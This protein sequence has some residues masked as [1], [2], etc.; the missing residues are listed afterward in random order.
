V[1]HTYT[2]GNGLADLSR[3]D[4]DNDV[5]HE[6]ILVREDVSIFAQNQRACHLWGWFFKK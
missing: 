2:A 6:K 4:D 1:P 3:A 5:I